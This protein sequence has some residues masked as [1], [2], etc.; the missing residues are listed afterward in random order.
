MIVL[1]MRV[2]TKSFTHLNIFGVFAQ[3]AISVEKYSGKKATKLKKI[4]LFID[5][6]G[7]IIYRRGLEHYLNTNRIYGYILI[8]LAVLVN[9]VRFFYFIRNRFVKN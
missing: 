9:P 1:D 4:Y 2:H 7:V 8:S 5:S 3:Y 6:I